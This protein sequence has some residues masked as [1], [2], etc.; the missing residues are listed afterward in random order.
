MGSA[1][2]DTHRN[3]FRVLG[4]CDA[5]CLID[6]CTYVLVRLLVVF[7]VSPGCTFNCWPQPAVTRTAAVVQDHN[8]AKIHTL[9]QL[10]LSELPEDSS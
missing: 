4:V 5:I 6:R 10:S 7:S 1:P 8:N 2:G 9:L 3:K